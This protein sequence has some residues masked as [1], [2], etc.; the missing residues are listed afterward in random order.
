MLALP[1]LVGVLGIP[2]LP[3]SGQVV[4]LLIAV[5]AL[6]LIRRHVERRRQR[7]ISTRPEFGSVLE[8]AWLSGGAARAL[9]VAMTQLLSVGALEWAHDAARKAWVFRRREGQSIPAELLLLH[10]LCAGGAAAWQLQVL[11]QGALGAAHWKLVERGWWIDAWTSRWARFWSSLP[12]ALVLLGSL[13]RASVT[14]DVDLLLGS[15]QVVAVL[16]LFGNVWYAPTRTRLGTRVL[17]RAVLPDPADPIDALAWRVARDG[18]SCLADTAA[19]QWW[20][21]RVQGGDRRP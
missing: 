17:Q 10:Q 1:V 3:E 12:L 8:Y 16:L 14:G 2:A 19:G 5:V 21:I 9:D 18:P 11:T 7:S 15:L 4:L 20:E 6:P 13:L